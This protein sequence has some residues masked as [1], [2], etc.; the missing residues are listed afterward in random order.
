MIS[1]RILN[2]ACFWRV[3]L[4]FFSK[5]WFCISKLGFY[6]YVSG[7]RSFFELCCGL[8]ICL[9]SVLVCGRPRIRICGCPHFFL[10]LLVSKDRTYRQC[11][12]LYLTM[13]C[14]YD[15]MTICGSQSPP[16]LCGSS[17]KKKCAS[18][19]SWHMHGPPQKLRVP[20][21]KNTRSTAILLWDRRDLHWTSW[22][23]PTFE[24]LSAFNGF[25]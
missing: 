6:I 5:S 3:L 2:I 10:K 11:F 13:Q 1:M 17:L 21:H 19:W 7:K 23:V 20:Q 14:L 18:K 4:C 9:F 22:W 16:R 12:W 24:H 25:A 8:C 15:N